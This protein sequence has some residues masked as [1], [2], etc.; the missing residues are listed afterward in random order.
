MNQNKEN[1]KKT[2]DKQAISYDTDIVGEHARNLYAP[3]L[4]KLKQ[5]E[6]VGSLLDLGCGTGALLESIF[7]LNITRQL[8]G[9]DLSSNM[10]EEAKKKIGDNAK[11]Y[12]GDAENLPFENSLFDTVIC[13]DS[14]HHYPS[15][16]K[17]VKE[18]SRV[19]KKGGLFIIGDCWQPA[20]ARQIMNFY[21][22]HSKSGDVKIYSKK[23]MENLLSKDFGTVLW[24]HISN[25]SSLTIARK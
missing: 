5:E 10:I 1:S 16:D 20:G 7:N 11:L 4:K 18:V 14:F 19:L 25:T 24:E 13:N 23:E 2:F 17:V 21:M 15:P 6:H 12:L 3:I 22:K 9:I 8:S